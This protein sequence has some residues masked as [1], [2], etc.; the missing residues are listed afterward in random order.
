MSR[1][2]DTWGSLGA[3]TA[4][5]EL[6]EGS[7]AWAVPLTELVAELK[8]DLKSGLSAAEAKR[9]HEQFGPNVIRQAA[10][11]TWVVVFLAQ[12]A[13]LMVAL[14]VAAAIIS[15]IIGEWT[16]ALLIC[17]IVIGNAITGFSQEWTAERAI[18]SLRRLTEPSARVCR[19]GSWHE[20]PAVQ[21]VSGDLIEIVTGDMIPADARVVDTADLETSEASLTGE[22]T[23]IEKSVEPVAAELPVPDRACVVYSGTSVVSGHGRAIVTAIGSQTELGRIAELLSTARPAQTPLQQR[24]DAFSRQM[25]IGIVIGAIVMFVIGYERHGLGQML[26]TSVGLAVAAM[27][28]GLPAVITI[29]LAIGAKRMTGRNAIVRRLTAVETLGSV[30]VICTDKTGT[31]TQNRMTVSHVEASSSHPDARRDLLHASI[32]CSDAKLDADGKVLGSPTESAFL[33]HA[34]HDGLDVDTVRKELER[35]DESPFTSDRKRMATLHRSANGDHV[36][37][38]K[39]A[40]ERVIPC[41]KSLAE[42]PDSMLYDS[43]LQRAHDI[44]GRGERV[45]AFARRVWAKEQPRPEPQDWDH[46]LEYLGLIALSDPIRPEVPEAIDRCRSAGIRPILITGDHPE[47]ARAIA[48]QIGI[49]QPGDIVLTGPDLEKFSDEQLR[50]QAGK[51]SVYARVSPEHKL[52]IVKGHQALGAVTSMTGDGV[53]DA[54]ALKQADIGVAMGQNGT[55]VAK[56]ASAMVLA[57]DN[58]ASIVAAV[59]EGRA[60]YDNIRKSIVY[61]I[62]GNA[63][64]VLILFVA[65][66]LGLPLP[67]FPIQ[68]LW[69]NL[70]TDGVPALAMAFEPPEADVM[71]RTPRARTENLLGRGWGWGILFVGCTVAISLLGLFHSLLPADRAD[72]GQV[73]YAQT[74]VFMTLALAELFYAFSTRDLSGPA[75]FPGLWKNKS[76]VIAILLGTLLQFVVCYVTPLQPIFHTTSLSLRDLAICLGVSLTGFLA[77]EF[78]KLCSRS[79]LKQ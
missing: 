21:L 72:V 25:T 39:G 34:I 59:E 41:C 26:L 4:A 77:M 54:P 46:S 58:F 70:V 35:V 65:L 71:K 75:N 67:L 66:I 20:V 61:L 63:A 30:N 76:L 55:D 53:N 11:R 5:S 78:W 42:T 10:G 1:S 73:K 14:L 69:I 31:L 68:I 40:V 15:G 12:F 48:E 3:P 18:E 33:S 6:N 2:R 22:S 47:T 7:C 9:R 38:V 45:L 44:S 56:D 37:F 43:V 32:H 24:L 60:V 28:E 79:W 13:N 64:E 16:D 23:P 29:G 57:D 62:A 19:N 74:A 50:Q 36:L 51:T 27:P 52:R 49:W 17:L 8:S